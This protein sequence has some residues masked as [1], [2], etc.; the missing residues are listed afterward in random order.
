VDP[1]GGY[2]S[3]HNRKV[4][5]TSELAAYGETIEP[6][7]KKALPRAGGKSSV[8]KVV[9]IRPKPDRQELGCLDET[10]TTTHVTAIQPGNYV[11]RA[12]AQQDPKS[13]V[14]SQKP[15]K[16][17]QRT[18]TLDGQIPPF[19]LVPEHKSN[20]A[21]ASPLRSTKRHADDR[22]PTAYYRDEAIVLGNLK[23][24]ER[25]GSSNTLPIWNKTTARTS[26]SPI[27]GRQPLQDTTNLRPKNCAEVS[28]SLVPSEDYSGSDC[29]ST[30]IYSTSMKSSQASGPGSIENTSAWIV[31][32]T[33]PQIVEES[34]ETSQ[35]RPAE[36]SAILYAPIYAGYVNP[37]DL[38]LQ[39]N[40]ATY[41]N[42][43]SYFDSQYPV[44]LDIAGEESMTDLFHKVMV[45]GRD[46]LNEYEE[47]TVMNDE[48]MSMG[49]TT[50]VVEDATDFQAHGSD[51]YLELYR[52]AAAKSGFLEIHSTDQAMADDQPMSPDFIPAWGQ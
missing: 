4:T 15:R 8:A 19:R 10:G 21:M 5:L 44:S 3:E 14:V 24:P 40:E 48:S 27:G 32:D 1:S 42:G 34:P 36:P 46:F 11:Q 2:E 7:F 49:D 51:L 26:K 31:K 13:F 6:S 12:Q 50:T 28:K 41:I 47:D 17:K 25:L 52:R 18:T 20:P 16:K 9:V 29:V 30:H 45:S 33:L 43:P 23:E 35:Y 39:P 38:H 22:K 37:I